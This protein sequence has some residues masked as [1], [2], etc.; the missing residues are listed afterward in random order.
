MFVGFRLLPFKVTEGKLQT[1]QRSRL[2]ETNMSHEYLAL[3]EC[4]NKTA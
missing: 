4:G 1:A 2:S 3:R